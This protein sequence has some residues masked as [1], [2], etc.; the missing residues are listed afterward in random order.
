ME[1]IF[2]IEFEKLTRTGKLVAV[3]VALNDPTKK[4]CVNKANEKKNFDK[5]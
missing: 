4:I 5:N 2:F 3:K 1:F